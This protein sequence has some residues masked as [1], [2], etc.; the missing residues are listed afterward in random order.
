MYTYED[1]LLLAGELVAH[2]DLYSDKD[3][4]MDLCLHAGKLRGM[5]AAG[6]PINSGQFADVIDEA[7]VIYA[8]ARLRYD[9]KRVS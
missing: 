3:D 7:F 2:A 5:V 6:E 9:T 4:A 1:V 8:T